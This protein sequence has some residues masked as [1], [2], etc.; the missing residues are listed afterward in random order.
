MSNTTKC[1]EGEKNGVNFKSS[2]SILNEIKNLFKIP[3][4]PNTQ[5]IDSYSLAYLGGEKPGL[6]PEKIAARIINR[7]SEA[8]LFSGLIAG[9]L[10]APDE[11]MELIRMEEI[12]KALTQE[13]RIDVCTKP[14]AQLQATGANA[15]GGMTVLGTTLTTS[16]G[17]GQSF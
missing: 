1:K 14:G 11:I 13:M 15:G 2:K 8:G 5:L 9:G 17:H 16:C 12:V 10:T 3:T 6:S 7:K 4:S